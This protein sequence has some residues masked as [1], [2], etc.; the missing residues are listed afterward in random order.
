LIG[1]SPQSEGV[2]TKMGSVCQRLRDHYAT[3]G[4]FLRCVSRVYQFNHFASLC[5]FVYSELDS[6]YPCMI[7]NM[8]CQIVILKHA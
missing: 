6:L 1:S 4:A 2:R 7:L 3:L 5:S 8:L